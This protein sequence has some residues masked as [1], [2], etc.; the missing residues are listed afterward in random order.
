MQFNSLDFLIFFPL[1]VLI[2]FLLPHK[3]RKYFLLLASVYFYICFVP[4]YFLIAMFTMLVDF[5][6][7]LLIDKFRDKKWLKRTFFITGLIL[8]LSVFIIYKYLGF[9]GDTINFFGAMINLETVYLPELIIP[10]GISFHTFQSMGYFI[11]A[12]KGKI[13]V[14]RNFIDFTLFLMFFPQLVAGPIERY[15]NLMDQLKAKHTFKA[16]NLSIGGRH[17]LW[18][19]FKKV[20]VADSLAWI[21][22]AVFDHPEQFSGFGLV[23]GIVCFAFQIYCDFSGYSDIAIGA[24]KI[25]DIDLMKNFDTPYFSSSTPEFWRRWH[26]SLST[27]F[28]DY[29]YI[30][31]GGNRVSKPRWVLNQ[32]IT[33][34]ASGFWHGAGLTFVA[35]GALNG[36]YIVISRFTKPLRDKLKQ[37]TRLEKLP[38]LTKPFSI[39]VTFCLICFTWIFFRAEDFSDAAYIISNIFSPT[40]FS[41]ENLVSDFRVGVAIFALILFVAIELIMAYGKKIVDLFYRA[42]H[43]CRALLYLGLVI[44]IVLL[45]DHGGRP[46]NYFDF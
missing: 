6:G 16:E 23:I 40:V 8:N 14:E 9:I 1:V 33:F 25:M 11:D 44:V 35:W 27:W 7:A 17:M 5:F 42:P 19:M 32:M 26:I 24:A 45:G 12:Y 30:P 29:L 31:L 34:V 2:F 39:L 18:G 38:W 46:N 41:L 3:L 10:I 20:V 22:D 28:K 43:A 21:A 13:K 36:V 37:L 15:S 4:K